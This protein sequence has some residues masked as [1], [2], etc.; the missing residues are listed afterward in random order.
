MTVKELQQ[1][2]FTDTG[3]KT[4]V[5]KCKGS[6]KGY[7]RVMPMFQGGKYPNFPHDYLPKIKAE[8][9]D[10]DSHEK[11]L[12]VTVSEVHIYGIDSEDTGK[13]KRER[14]PKQID[15]NSNSKQ[16]GSKNSQMRLDKAAARYAKLL[17]KDG[18]RARYY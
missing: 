7:I 9:K 16:W 11:P 8:F 3:L 10:Y 15:E 6:M 13:Y 4:T 5:S 17:R 1:Q 18:N 14:K 12:F 2:I